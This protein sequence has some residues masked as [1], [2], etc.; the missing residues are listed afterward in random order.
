VTSTGG[1][2]GALSTTVTGSGSGAVTGMGR[3]IADDSSDRSVV[4]IVGGGS[5]FGVA[6]GVVS[7]AAMFVTNFGSIATTLTSGIG[8]VAKMFFRCAN[9]K[10]EP[11]GNGFP[12]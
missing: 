9:K 6:P 7:V 12:A 1:G 2:T 11:S 10:R 3:G 5:P 4:G 8:L